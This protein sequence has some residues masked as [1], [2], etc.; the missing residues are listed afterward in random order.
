VSDGALVRYEYGE[1]AARRAAASFRWQI[2]A[3]GR[4][5][6]QQNAEGAVRPD[7]ADDVYWYDADW[8]EQTRLAPE[9]LAAVEAIARD[10]GVGLGRHEAAGH[11]EGAW[12]RLTLPG[13][14]I[15]VEDDVSP[16][17]EAVVGRILQVL[18]PGAPAG[19][20]G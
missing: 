7:D 20:P 2:C 19:R 4:Y 3:D 10:P 1:K 9:Q 14:V 16:D 6:V 11:P 5:L 8:H 17:L 15:E 12:A 13:G 18:L